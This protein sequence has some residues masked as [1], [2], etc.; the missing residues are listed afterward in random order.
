VGGRGGE[1]ERTY[2]VEGVNADA[3]TLLEA[4]G[5]ETSH[6]LA[7]DCFGLSG[8]DGARSISGIDVDLRISASSTS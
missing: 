2:I 7:N 4:I 1:V 3:I 6:D 5:V 8:G